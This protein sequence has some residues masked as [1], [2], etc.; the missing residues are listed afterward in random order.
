MAKNYSL[1]DQ[2]FNA[3]KVGYLAGLFRNNDPSFDP[4]F[5]ARCLS[6]FPDLELK[7]RIAWIAECL[8]P[9]LPDHFTAASDV[10]E[11]ALPPPLDPTAS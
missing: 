8:I 5:E 3:E 4:E 10:I 7:G 1:K 2:L 9:A 11:A 6:R